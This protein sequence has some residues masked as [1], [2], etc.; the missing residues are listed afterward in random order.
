MAGWLGS[1]GSAEGTATAM[2]RLVEL[3]T[4]HHFTRNGMRTN[5][6][7]RPENRVRDKNGREW[8][9]RGPYSNTV[10]EGHPIVEHVNS[11]GVPCDAVC[12]NRRRADSVTPP[13]GRHRDG[14]NTGHS[15]IAFWGCPE[16]EGALA[17]EDGRRSTEQQVLHY[18]GDL[19]QCTHW[20]EPH[21]TGTR[22]SVVCFSGP[23]PS[24]SRR[25]RKYSP[26]CRTEE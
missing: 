17:L 7:T 4:S 14:E 20:V 19:S 1:A 13:M 16:G 24:T 8:L 15:W 22:Y 9:R 18:C 6:D 2:E 26:D 25:R 3:T 5:V 11:M 12:L 23:P 10:R 21:T